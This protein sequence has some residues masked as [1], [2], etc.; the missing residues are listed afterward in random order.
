MK[1]TLMFEHHA[2]AVRMLN[3]T[4][5]FCAAD[6]AKACGYANSFPTKVEDR[7]QMVDGRRFLPLGKMSNVLQRA[8]G[9][10]R[11]RAQELNALIEREYVSHIP[12]PPPAVPA[13]VQ[14][15]VELQLKS[16]QIKQEILRLR[17]QYHQQQAHI[18]EAQLQNQILESKLIER[19]SELHSLNI[20]KLVP[21]LKAVSNG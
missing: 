17:V 8:Q 6:I 15:D 3:G 19:E 7:V 16:G 4:P 9:L 12:T 2:I 5:H 10:R 11:E 20:P 13:P 18:F 21:N 14:D 1:S